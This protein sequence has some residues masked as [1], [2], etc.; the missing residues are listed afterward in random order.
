MESKTELSN[1]IQV[2]IKHLN[3]DEGYR[4]TWQANIAMSFK[5]EYEANKNDPEIHYIANNAAIRFLHN[6]TREVKNG[7]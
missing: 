1:A 6:L 2:L 4:Y 5:D 7:N 3:E